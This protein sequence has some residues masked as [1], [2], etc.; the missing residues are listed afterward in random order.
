MIKKSGRIW[1][2]YQLL[3][4]LMIVY[5]RL[6]LW[7]IHRRQCKE[8]EEGI[9]SPDAQIRRQCC[10]RHLKVMEYRKELR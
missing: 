2:E 9:H 6:V 10:K 4:S 7:R 1:A 8:E 3:S 5:T